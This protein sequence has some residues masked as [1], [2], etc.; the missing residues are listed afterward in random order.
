MAQLRRLTDGVWA[1]GQIGLADL[2]AAKA[3]GVTLVVGNRPDGEDPGQPTAAQ[4]EATARAL[5][6][7]YRHIPIVG[8]PSAEQVAAVRAALDEADGGVLLYCRSGMRSAAAWA[9]GEPRPREAVLAD[10]AG[11][12]FNLAG[13]L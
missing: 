9:M 12:G 7:D 11:A 5:G 1:A 3:L 4:T 8:R 2:E 13:V 10:A 6:L